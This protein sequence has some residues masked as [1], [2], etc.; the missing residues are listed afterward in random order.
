MLTQ[1]FPYK[2]PK[3]F[4]EEELTVAEQLELAKLRYQ[5]DLFMLKKGQATVLLRWRGEIFGMG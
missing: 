2:S 4:I 5:A 1:L 3:T